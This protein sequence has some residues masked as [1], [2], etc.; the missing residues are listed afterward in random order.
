M[1][2]KIF[3]IEF[4]EKF[5]KIANHNIAIMIFANKLDSSFC[6]VNIILLIQICSI[7]DSNILYSEPSAFFII[8]LVKNKIIQLEDTAV[9]MCGITNISMLFFYSTFLGRI[10]A[11]IFN[12]VDKRVETMFADILRVRNVLPTL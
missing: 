7:G 11:H 2:F 12:I 8:A 4:I 9:N 10:F 1:L 6:K 3:V 5:C